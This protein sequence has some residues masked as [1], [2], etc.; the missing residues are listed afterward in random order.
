MVGPGICIDCSPLLVR[1]AGVKTWLYHWLRALREQHPER[2]QTLFE[3]GAGDLDHAGGLRLHGA[4]LAMLQALNLL[5]PAVVDFLTHGA[6]VFHA[7]NLLRTIPARPRLSTTLHDLTAWVVPEFHR[8]EQVAGD[9]AFAERVL[10]R[11]DGVIA[12]SENTRQDAVRILELSPEKIRVIYPGAGPEYFS[13]KQ[14]QQAS[15]AKTCGLVLPYFLFA[16]T[17][18]PRKNI[19]TLLTAWMQLPSS[20]RSESNLVILGMPGW[21]SAETLRRLTQLT[22]EPS[23]VRYLGYVPE[24]FVPGL[25]ASAQAL[26]YPS[27]YEGFGIPVAQAMAAGCPVIASNVASLP[28]VTGGAALLIDPRSPGEIANAIRRVKESPVLA[29]QLRSA[30]RERARLFTWDRAARESLEYFAALTSS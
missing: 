27:F 19:D 10:K 15:A 20:F 5:P 11:A 2:I 18:E 9:L 30:G 29:D 13:V 4:R 21:K 28:E 26:I 12:V 14:E 7:S 22:R 16:G 17:I 6:G 25:T 23:G 3:P 1:S 24:S 8:P